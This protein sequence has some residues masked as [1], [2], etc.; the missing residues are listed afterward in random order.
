[1]RVV[2]VLGVSLFCFGALVFWVRDDAIL[3]VC[4]KRATGTVVTIAQRPGSSV[5]QGDYDIGYR[6]TTANGETLDS[7]DVMPFGIIGDLE[8]GDGIQIAYHPGNPK[9]NRIDSQ[10]SGTPVGFLVLGLSGLA[11]A[12]VMLRAMWK[13]RNADVSRPTNQ[14]F[15]G[16]DNLLGNSGNTD[17]NSTDSHGD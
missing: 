7:K 3:L 11:Y 4:R 1:M 13:A 8:K 9:T 2:V 14:V 16:Q 6:F 5:R 15:R 12:V 17:R 10:V